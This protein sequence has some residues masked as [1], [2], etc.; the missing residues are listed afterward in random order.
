MNP[1]EREYFVSRLRSGIYN[2][3][4]DGVF[5]KV[6]SPT[7]EDEFYA[8]EL[9]VQA[10]EE[11][12][13]DDI[14]TEEHILAWAI[15]KGLWSDEKEQKI[16]LLEKD[17]EKLKV[18]IFGNRSKT[19]LREK[20]RTYIR[21]TEKALKKAQSEKNEWFSRT[22]EGI[23]TEEKNLALFSRCCFVGSEPLD[24]EFAD[25]NTLY[26]DY[27]KMQLSE[28]QLREIAR[29]EPWRLTWTLREQQ[30]LFANAPGRQLTND[31]KGLLIWSRMYDNIQ[32]SMDCPTEDVI[33]DDDM[34]DGWFIT[35]KKKQ[36][37]EKAKSEL[38]ARTNNEKI[39][40][41][42]EVMIVTDSAKEADRIH[43]MNSFGAETIRKQR[44]AKVRAKGGVK[45][46]LEFQDVQL[47]A[48]KQMKEATLARV[49]GK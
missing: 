10:Y 40:N 46:D 21:A 1:Y 35:Q 22:C 43:G 16:E 6:V 32:E 49:K 36:E 8:N 42:P 37:A 4:L 34:L 30:P 15:E 19:I 18:E 44:L 11:A 38:E 48:R 17:L 23:A 31:Q 7:I 26:Y 12:L 3:R 47:D 25:I 29:N 45:S 2:I 33:N 14:M 5:I 41:S 24:F 13:Y 20:I 28:K 27:S 39:A 9:Y